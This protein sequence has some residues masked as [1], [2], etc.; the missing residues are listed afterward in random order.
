[1]P[2]RAATRAFFLTSVIALTA[3]AAGACGGDSGGAGPQT[4]G[5]PAGSASASASGSASAAS[6][7]AAPAG[8][9]VAVTPGGP[10]APGSLMKS[11]GPSAFTEDLKKLGIDPLRPPPLAKLSPDVIRKLMP[12]FAKSLGVKCEGCHDVNDFKAPTPAKNVAAGMWQHFVVELSLASGE[13]LYC[14]SCHGGKKEFLD[15]HDKKALGQ[16][17]DANYVAKLKRSDKKDHGC[18]TCHGDPF[19]PEFLKD[20]AARPA[21]GK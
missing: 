21:T 18:E 15:A 20:W 19:K 14:D 17:M 2:S 13:P 1:M 12:T 11:P 10:T 6:G 3:A 9:G 7:P 8:S 5:G 4:P 16:W